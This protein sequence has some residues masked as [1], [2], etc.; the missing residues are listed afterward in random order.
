MG[1]LGSASQC[2]DPALEPEVAGK[3]TGSHGMRWDRWD[4]TMA[5]RS[6]GLQAFGDCDTRTGAERC[7]LCPNVQPG[8]S[9]PASGQGRASPEHPPWP[10]LCWWGLPRI[11]LGNVP[12]H[13]GFILIISNPPT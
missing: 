10:G 3:E 6:E 5:R 13:L 1:K 4:L 7:S 8:V 9:I 12:H 2:P 11:D